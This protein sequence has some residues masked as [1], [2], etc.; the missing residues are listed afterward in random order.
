M[1]SLK[2]NASTM[3]SFE[4]PP[5]NSSKINS[6]PHFLNFIQK[7]ASLQ[8]HFGDGFT[9]SL[10]KYLN[11]YNPPLNES[12]QGY[13]PLTLLGKM[14]ELSVIHNDVFHEASFVLLEKGALPHL[15]NDEGRHFLSFIWNK[16]R[17]YFSYIEQFL[18]KGYSLDN[19]D[20]DVKDGITELMGNVVF[21]EIKTISQKNKSL[22]QANKLEQFSKS[23]Q[24][25]LD[26]YFNI[27]EKKQEK[28]LPLE[29]NPFCVF[30]IRWLGWGL[31]QEANQF[32]IQNK[33][34]LVEWFKKC[35]QKG[36]DINQPD[37][38]G[39]TVVHYAIEAQNKEILEICFNHDADM[40]PTIK[41]R[42]NPR[43]NLN[44][45]EFAFNY[46]FDDYRQWIT[47][48]QERL[49]LNTLP[50]AQAPLKSRKI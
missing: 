5:K 29:S 28:G 12:Y 4:T 13:T 26:F 49:K 15:L 31:R 21:P 33:E 1:S 10:K 8:S 30:F 36:L 3:P 9:K 16:N 48:K 32:L 50:L 14:Y 40:F 11:Q 47:S 35:H 38:E 25:K 22:N 39:K 6:L 2:T 46:R 24:N 45:D 43:L 17:K 7:K 44:I 27:L 34:L 37:E 41:N 19:F 20:L 23:A 18:D 42:L